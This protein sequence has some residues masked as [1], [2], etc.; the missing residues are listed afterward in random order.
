MNK[1]RVV[2][3]YDKLSDDIISAIR[4]EYP[5]G[6][7][8]KLI[9]FRNKLGKLVSALPFETEDK[10]Y[11]IRMTAV[12][13]QNILEEEEEDEENIDDIIDENIE[14]ETNTKGNNKKDEDEDE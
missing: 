12:Q 3:D 14:Q 5:Y 13:A 1:P 2:K 9:M 10:Y 8:K 4:I 7:E 11:L 6:F